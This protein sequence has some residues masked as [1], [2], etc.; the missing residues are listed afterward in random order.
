MS[1]ISD[2]PG[3]HPLTGRGPRQSL[4]AQTLD[5]SRPIAA[6]GSSPSSSRRIR[7]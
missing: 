4:L 1:Q 2:T 6:G 5:S 7:R 3:T